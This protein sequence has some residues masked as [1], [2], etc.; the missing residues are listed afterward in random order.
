VLIDAT[1]VRA[2]LVPALM[3]LLG[4]SSW[5]APAPLTALHKRLGLDRLEGADTPEPAPSVSTTIAG[6]RAGSVGAVGTPTP[7]AEPTDVAVVK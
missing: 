2:L 7:V 6:R 4:R 3:A 5:W 1:L